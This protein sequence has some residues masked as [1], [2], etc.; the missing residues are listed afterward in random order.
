[1]K[2]IAKNLRLV[3]RNYIK[4]TSL[5]SAIGQIVSKIF[6]FL[7]ILV[8]YLLKSNID[9][10]EQFSNQHKVAFT[11]RDTFWSLFLCSKFRWRKQSWV[12]LNANEDIY[13]Q[14]VK[15]L[16]SELDWITIINSIRRLNFFVESIID[17]K[18]KHIFNEIHTKPIKWAQPLFEHS[19]VQSKP[20]KRDESSFNGLMNMNKKI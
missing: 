14:G 9:R 13:K 2:A 20:N 19:Q 12:H 3:D 7:K 16:N 17:T 18:E 4:R 5:I 15:E 6:S 11:W 10:K 8:L 1:M